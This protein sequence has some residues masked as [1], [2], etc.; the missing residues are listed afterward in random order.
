MTGLEIIRLISL[1]LLKTKNIFNNH[2][3]EQSLKTPLIKRI[4]RVEE[5]TKS[6][7]N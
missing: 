3:K 6:E 4:K 7:T 5:N 2:K 1:W